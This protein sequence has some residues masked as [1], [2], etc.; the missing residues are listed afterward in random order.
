MNRLIAFGCSNT[1]GHGLEDCV[2]EDMQPGPTASK[3]AWPQLV[4]DKLGLECHNQALPGASNKM[5]MNLV[6]NFPFA[7][8]DT[9]VIMWTHSDR[10]HIFSDPKRIIENHSKENIGP[11]SKSRKAVTYYR[12]IYNKNDQKIM[13]DHYINYTSLYLEKHKIT[14]LQTTSSFDLTHPL[15]YDIDYSNIRE[16]YPKAIDNMHVGPEA[17]DEVA[18]RIYKRIS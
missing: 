18:N 10:Y 11:W 5:I 13:T 17:H 7:P 15:V 4:A 16:E 12:Q 14:H 2:T 6:M 1:F 8:K 9:V 3:L